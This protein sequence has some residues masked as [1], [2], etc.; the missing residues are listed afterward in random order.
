MFFLRSLGKC[1]GS[2]V[3]KISLQ[4][5]CEDNEQVLFHPLGQMDALWTESSKYKAWMMDSYWIQRVTKK[6]KGDGVEHQERK[7]SIKS[8]QIRKK[9]GR[10]TK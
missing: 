10:N 6:R 8:F 7:W 1:H 2:C 5:D 4:L 9:L 3:I